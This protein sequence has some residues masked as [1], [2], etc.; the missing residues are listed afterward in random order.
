MKHIKKRDKWRV[1]KKRK[2]QTSKEESTGRLTALLLLLRRGLPSGCEGSIEREME[3]ERERNGRPSPL[4][5]D[6]H[7]HVQMNENEKKRKKARKEK[8]KK[9]NGTNVIRQNNL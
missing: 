7:S 5:C 3:R 4:L 2:G 9:T 6:T 8:R 1:E